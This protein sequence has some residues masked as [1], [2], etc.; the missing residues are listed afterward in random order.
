MTEAGTVKEL[1]EKGDKILEEADT[2]LLSGTLSSAFIPSMIFPGEERTRQNFKAW[3]KFWNKDRVYNLKK[4]MIEDA[5]GS[6]FTMDAFEPFYK[7]ISR[8]SFQPTGTGIPER[9]FSFLGIS[10]STG[11]SSWIQ[12][13]LRS[14]M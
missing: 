7:M 3:K 10:K 6:G 9:F 4:N 12:F 2:D 13:S 14:A 11:K 5:S 8:K 1:Q